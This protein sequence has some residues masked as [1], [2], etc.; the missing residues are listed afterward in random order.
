M[1]IST[2][3]AGTPNPKLKLA[4]NPFVFK[5]LPVTHYESNIWSTPKR[6]NDC[7]QT[8][9]PYPPGGVGGVPQQQACHRL[10]HPIWSKVS[11]YAH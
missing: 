10:V 7:K 9:Y 2:Q 6:V 5:F 11:L 1:K 4:S 3:K 8:I